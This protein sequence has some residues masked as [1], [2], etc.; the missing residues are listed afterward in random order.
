M[1][2]SYALLAVMFFK[3]VIL[4]SLSTRHHVYHSA[5]KT[6]ASSLT[7]RPRVSVLVP[8]Y[9]EERTLENCI[10]SLLRQDYPN[11]EI[12][13]IN[14]GS[15][16][17]TI[18]IAKKLAQMNS[19]I[20]LINKS[21]NGKALALN[22]GIEASNGDIIVSMDADSIFLSST[23]S[24]L[25]KSFE[26]PSVAA[27]SGNIRVANRDSFIGKQQ[28]V[29]YI[30]GLTIQRSAFSYLG[31]MQVISG[32]IGAFRKEVLYEIGGYS[33][34]TIVEDMEITLALAYSKYKIIYNPKAIAYTEAPESLNNFIRQR[35]RWTFGGFQVISK[36]KSL[37]FKRHLNKMGFIGLPYFIVFPWLD[38]MVSL[39][40]IISIVLVT[41]T[42]KWFELALFFM[43]M[44]TLQLLLVIYAI[45][46]DKENR[47]LAPISLFDSLF[48]SHLISFVTVM[49]GIDYLNNKKAT[50]SKFERKGKNI[51][52]ELTQ[53]KL[54][55][56]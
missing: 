22:T 28:A 55:Y 37:L 39:L 9:N 5:L 8:C 3:I 36:Y 49:A 29:E 47:N 6:T 46:I 16:D 30:M 7:T 40:L 25:V 18:K 4:L 2:I 31:C 17:N 14:D 24:E 54:N 53:N 27:V 43:A 1:L 38:V 15:T 41:L 56:N 51:I 50:W 48:Y 20:K 13:I 52:S 19:N 35:Y 32:A 10:F 33:N 34:D 42:G 21:N 23:I 12:I 45:S 44:S 26:D 11:F